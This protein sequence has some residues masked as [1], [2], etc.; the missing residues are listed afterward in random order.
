MA[1]HTPM[2][3]FRIPDA[4]YEA[5]LKKAEGEGRTLAD[6]VRELLRGYVKTG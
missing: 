6:V 1:Q 4:L 3:T 5:A 2:R